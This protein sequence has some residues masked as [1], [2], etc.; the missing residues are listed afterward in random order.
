MIYEHLY[1]V[2]IDEYGLMPDI[3]KNKTGFL[4]IVLMELQ[5]NID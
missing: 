2:Q 4:G 1:D 3:S 5:Q